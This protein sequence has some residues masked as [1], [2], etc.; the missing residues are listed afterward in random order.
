MVVTMPLY[1][2]CDRCGKRLLVG[3]RCECTKRK[4]RDYQR[5]RTDKEY[6]KV[7]QDPRYKKAREV[8]L[9]KAKG[10]CEVCSKK[11]IISYVDDTH[12]IVPIKVDMSKAYDVNNLICLCRKCHQEAHRDMKSNIDKLSV[13]KRL[14]KG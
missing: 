8:A 4:Y 11:G 10:V 13:D 2:R 3:T 6:Q 12:H 9:L 5:H 14:N 7:Y 1:K